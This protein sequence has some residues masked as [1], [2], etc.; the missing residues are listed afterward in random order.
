[1]HTAAI[2]LPLGLESWGDQYIGGSRT[3]KVGGLGLVPPVPLVVVPMSS[4]TEMTHTRVLAQRD[5]SVKMVKTSTGVLC[6]IYLLEFHEICAT[7]WFLWH[8]DFT[9]FNFGQGSAPDPSGGA[10]D[11]PPGPLVSWGRGYPVPIPHHLDVLL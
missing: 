9:K 10:Y 8:S 3:S 2:L 7:R 1:V 4:V 6:L 5:Q 11:T